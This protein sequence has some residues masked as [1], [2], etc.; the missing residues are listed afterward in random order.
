MKIQI[1]QPITEHLLS[2]KFF[3]P[4]GS[5]LEPV[6]FIKRLQNVKKTN[7]MANLQFITFFS[8][9]TWFLLL[10]FLNFVYVV[11]FF[12]ILFSLL[13]Q[14]FNTFVFHNLKNKLISC[15]PGVYT[16]PTSYFFYVRSQNYGKMKIEKIEKY[17]ALIKK[18]KFEQW[19]T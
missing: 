11:V 8:I 6:G 17:F 4:I 12:P 1:Y 5:N 10:S 2:L 14:R 15:L 13:N 16:I 19:I 7:F 9:W 3:T 18:S